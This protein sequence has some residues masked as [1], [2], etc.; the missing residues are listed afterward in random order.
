[1]P[2]TPTSAP[3]SSVAK[4]PASSCRNQIQRNASAMSRFAM[5]MVVCGYRALHQKI[6]LARAAWR[7]CSAGG[8]SYIDPVALATLW[9]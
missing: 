8:W 5:R 6:C 2:W 7:G 4:R 1:M 3:G 9:S